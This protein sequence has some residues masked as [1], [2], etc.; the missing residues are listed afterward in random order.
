MAAI[1]VFRG[2][3]TKHRIAYE[4]ATSLSDLVAA[5]FSLLDDSLLRALIDAAIAERDA[6]LAAGG[7]DSELLGTWGAVIDAVQAETLKRRE[8]AAR[9]FQEAC[10]L[11]ASPSSGADD[12][13][14][15]SYLQGM[16]RGKHLDHVFCDL[17]SSSLQ[18]VAG[19]GNSTMMNL[20]QRIEKAVNDIIH[21]P[22][23]N[24]IPVA[25][26]NAEALQ[27]EKLME[28]GS[29]LQLMLRQ[30]GG[31]MKVLTLE[32]EEKYRAGLIDEAFERVLRDN[33]SACEAAGY[34]NKTQVLRYITAHIQQLKES[35]SS[36]KAD[37]RNNES[38]F[39]VVH[40]PHFIMDT[41]AASE[42]MGASEE[43]SEDFIDAA[44]VFE[45]KIKNTKK[46]AEKNAAKRRI[47]NV[48]RSLGNHLQQHGWAVCDHFLPL[49][50]VRRVRIEACLFQDHYE[51]SEIWVGKGSAV[52]AQI[53][54]KS[55]RG[56]RVLWM[57]GGHRNNP[58]GNVL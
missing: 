23:S 41:V 10:A 9:H 11:A 7:R 43:L 46:K 13:A 32:L 12:G 24:T 45:N 21:T 40:A 6:K 31:D 17:V 27:Q 57:C 37:N 34:A 30:C 38:E 2:F 4:D 5:N 47:I 29:M 18:Q 16:H 51:S 1:D 3:L 44:G 48:A 22:A 20:L 35:A 50:L 8:A 15:R 42:K 25:M 56:D 19:S 14:L 58:A 54:V 53:S 26:R 49:D 39:G 52:G 36:S 28:A 55:V 33:L